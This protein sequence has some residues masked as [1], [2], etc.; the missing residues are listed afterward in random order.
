[1]PIFSI[2]LTSL[3]NTTLNPSAPPHL[4][5]PLRFRFILVSDFLSHALLTVT[6]HPTLPSSPY[7]AVSYPWT[8]LKPHPTDESAFFRV[9]LNHPAVPSTPLSLATIRTACLAARHHGAD[10]LWIDQ[11]CILQTSGE[12]KA[13]QVR[14]MFSLYQRCAVSL[15]LPG[16]LQRL[17][18]HDEG[19]NWIERAWTL[20]EA[21]PEETWV[22]FGW[23]RGSGEVTG[24][25]G[26]RVVEVERGRSG[27]M[28]LGGMLQVACVPGSARFAGE[29]VRFGVFGAGRD[30]M[31]ALMAVKEA[32][33]GR[34]GMREMAVWRSALMRTCSVA[35]D[36]VFSVM[37]VFGV[38]LEVERYGAGDREEAA[39]DLVFEIVKKGGRASWLGAALGCPVQSSMCS[40]PEFPVVDGR[41]VWYSVGGTRKRPWDVMGKGLDWYVEPTLEAA[42]KK[43]GSGKLHL[44]AQ[45][46]RVKLGSF[47][48]GHGLG[49][50]QWAGFSFKAV[51]ELDEGVERGR[52]LDGVYTARPLPEGDYQVLVVGRVQHYSLPA[53]SARVIPGAALL[54]IMQWNRSF[55]AWEILTYGTTM[56]IEDVARTWP[57]SVLEIGC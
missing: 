49:S 34:R 18:A 35:C 44:T 50:D 26:G 48:E 56:L 2:P 32:G 52:R 31:L 19:T 27:M 17:A 13:W 7:A 38:E 24:L 10:L 23:T 30:A 22:V 51:L 54:A 5:T 20:Q 11:V 21:M 25:A 12:D 6:S 16:G 43:R 47:E 8:G 36:M 55:E 42:I 14:R 4:A 3:A 53:V 45:T 37:G 46:L 28:K 39:A 40:L 1:M 57:R 29:E 41:E 9:A 15:V 33:P